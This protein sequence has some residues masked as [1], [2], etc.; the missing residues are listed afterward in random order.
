[1]TGQAVFTA[2]EDFQDE[3]NLVLEQRFA[4]VPEWVIDA[5]IRDCVYRLCSVPLCCGQSSGQ[6][7]PGRALLARR[8]KKSSCDTVDRALK[9]LVE[10]G[11]FAVERRRQGRQ[12]LTNRY[13]HHRG[14]RRWP[15]RPLKRSPAASRER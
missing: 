4:I 12:H 3:G 9:E 6:R 14:C 8:L 10:I 7:T 15:P 11:A 5:D 13:T 1:M 2:A